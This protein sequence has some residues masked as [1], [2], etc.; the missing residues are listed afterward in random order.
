MILNG[1]ESRL[2]DGFYAHSF[3]TSTVVRNYDRVVI[4]GKRADSQETILMISVPPVPPPPRPPV[5]TRPPPPVSA[6]NSEFVPAIG[7]SEADAVSNCVDL[8]DSQHAE[9][10][11]G[12]L[13]NPSRSMY[14][15]IQGSGVVIACDRSGVM[16]PAAG[17]TEQMAINACNGPSTHFTDLD[18]GRKAGA[19]LY[20]NGPGVAVICVRPI[21]ASTSPVSHGSTISSWTHFDGASRLVSANA[22]FIQLESSEKNYC[23]GRVRLTKKESQFFYSEDSY[24]LEIQGSWCSKLKV[25]FEKSGDTLLQTEQTVKF[26]LDKLSGDSLT[27]S[28][29]GGTFNVPASAIYT[30]GNG[31][32]LQ[33]I[34][35]VLYTESRDDTRSQGYEKLTIQLDQ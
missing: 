23:G 19:A 15:P 9:L 3:S 8:P 24:V 2:S 4:K 1:V 26:D 6:G 28:G 20:T 30:L 25:G 21:L 33:Q 31:S 34:S 11:R 29:Y 35:M 7:A 13:A 32:S 17:Q 16:V 14:S 27:W 10:G 18:L 12:Q 5:Y 22:G